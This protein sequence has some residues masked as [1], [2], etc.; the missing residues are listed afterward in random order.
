MRSDYKI[1]CRESLYELASC[2]GKTARRNHENQLCISK[3]LLMYYLGKKRKRKNK[4]KEQL[5]HIQY[6]NSER[7]SK[8]CAKSCFLK[9]GDSIGHKYHTSSRTLNKMLFLSLRYLSSQQFSVSGLYY[10]IFILTSEIQIQEK[11][12]TILTLLRDTVPNKKRT[13]ERVWNVL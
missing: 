13:H 11:F 4:L 7:T 1:L 6:S 9:C 3:A 8:S 12:L 10:I 5:Q 2:T